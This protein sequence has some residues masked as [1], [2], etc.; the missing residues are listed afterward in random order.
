MRS[1]SEWN[2]TTTSRPPGLRMRSAAAARA[3]SSPS[4]SLTKMRS[5]WNVRV[6]GWMSPGRA[7]TT[8]ATIS[9][10]ARGGA[11]SAPAARALHDGAGDGA[12]MALLAEQ[13]DDVGE[14]ALAR[15]VDHIGG[16]R[17]LRRSCA[18]RADR[19]GGTRSRVRPCRAAST[20][21]RDRARRRRRRRSRLRARRFRDWRSGPRPASAGRCDCATSSAPAR[22]RRGSRSMAMTLHRPRRGWRAYSRRRRRWRRYRRRRRAR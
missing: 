16:A 17:A 14:I 15:G 1:S 9:A 5:A 12:R 4:S 13:E 22:D 21:R 20:R 18:C 2:E 19:R 11:R 6:A 8:D 10:S 3:A 7:R